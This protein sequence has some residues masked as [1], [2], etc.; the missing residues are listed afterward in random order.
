MHL[1][2]KKEFVDKHKIVEKGEPDP[3]F[4]RMMNGK[5]ARLNGKNK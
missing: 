1:A 2:L 5:S 4:G 3:D